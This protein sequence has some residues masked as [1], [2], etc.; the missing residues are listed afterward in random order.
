[1]RTPARTACATRRW[2]DFWGRH[3]QPGRIPDLGAFAFEPSLATE[4][5]AVGWQG[6]PYRFAVK[7]EME[8]RNLWVQPRGS[9]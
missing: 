2:A 3:G 6:Y 8:L 1:M 9:H 7:G 4:Q 5:A